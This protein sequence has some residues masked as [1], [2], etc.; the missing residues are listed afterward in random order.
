MTTIRAYATA[1]PLALWIASRASI[2][3]LETSGLL[4]PPSGL[5]IDGRVGRVGSGGAASRTVRSHALDLL[6]RIAQIAEP[7]VRI[8]ADELDAPC[9]RL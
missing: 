1:R 4:A 5:K 6:H 7:A 3:D 8:A 9:K 2:T